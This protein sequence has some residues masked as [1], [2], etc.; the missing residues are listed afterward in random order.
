VP[1][2]GYPYYRGMDQEP[3]SGTHITL[4]CNLCGNTETVDTTR[5]FNFSRRCVGYGNSH[6]RIKRIFP[7]QDPETN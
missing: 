4:T 3:V 1:C 7:A 2:S 5:A 6:V